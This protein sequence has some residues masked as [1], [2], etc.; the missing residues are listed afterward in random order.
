MP[1]L[2]APCREATIP[3][4]DRGS[5]LSGDNDKRIAL[6]ARSY[7]CPIV[8]LDEPTS[9]LDSGT[10]ADLVDVMEQLTAGRTIMTRTASTLRHCDL[11]L[12][13]RQGQIVVQVPDWAARTP[14]ELVPC[15][16]RPLLARH[17]SE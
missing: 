8:I 5:R 10:E 13:L 9:A 3:V 17:R 15:E 11:Q 7:G 6:A 12:M 14:D 16:R 1:S 4:G 2:S